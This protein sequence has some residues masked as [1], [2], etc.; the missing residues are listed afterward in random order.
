MLFSASTPGRRRWIDDAVASDNGAGFR[1]LLQPTSTKSP[2]MG[3]YLFAAGVHALLAAADHHGQL[4][5]FHVGGDGPGAHV[6]L[7]A[8]IESPT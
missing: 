4:V 3:A 8:Q 6:G 1:T 5:A 2:S 7:I